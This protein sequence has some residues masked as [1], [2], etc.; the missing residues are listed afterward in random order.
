MPQNM[1]T[2]IKFSFSSTEGVLW[3]DT[4]GFDIARRINGSP[5]L[6]LQ[7]LYTHDGNSYDARGPDEIRE[8]GQETVDRIL[9][10]KQ[11]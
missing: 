11:K 8:I 10:L 6:H 4:D 2:K 3:D 9:E 5:D 1:K 7:G